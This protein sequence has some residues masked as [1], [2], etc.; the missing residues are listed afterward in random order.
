MCLVGPRGVLRNGSWCRR[1][2]SSRWCAAVRAIIVK[3]QKLFGIV[4]RTID[5]EATVRFAVRADNLIE[6][7]GWEIV[8]LLSRESR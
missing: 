6:R 7:A 2:I 5:D 3:Q 8:K 1:G 4:E